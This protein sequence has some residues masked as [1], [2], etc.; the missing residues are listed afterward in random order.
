MN[1]SNMFISFD[2][3]IKKNTK[4]GRCICMGK[5]HHLPFGFKDQTKILCDNIKRISTSLF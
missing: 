1:M 2:F 4:A 3:E 5:L